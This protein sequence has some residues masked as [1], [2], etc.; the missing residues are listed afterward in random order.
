V[1]LRRLDLTRA[2]LQADDAAGGVAALD[3]FL[4]DR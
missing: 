3:R 1:E 2:E 4:T